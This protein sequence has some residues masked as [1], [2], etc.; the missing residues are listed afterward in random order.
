MSK[1]D[2]TQ[3][4]DDD[5]DDDG[6]HG[7]F[8]HNR[9]IRGTLL[10]WSDSQHWTDRDGLKAPTPLLVVGVNDALQRWIDNKPQVIF[11]KPLPNEDDLNAAIPISEWELG[12][13]GQRRKPWAHVVVVY[14]IDPAAGGFYTYVSATTGAHIA[15]D[16][17]KEAVMSMRML[18]GGKVLPLVALGERPMKTKFGVKTRPH[19]EV[20]DWKTSAALPAA[21]QQE[22]LQAALPAAEPG[23]KL[24]LKPV[25]SSVKAAAPAAEPAKRSWKLAGETLSAMGGVKPVTAA[26]SLDDHI[27]Y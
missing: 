9:L 4:D 17:L 15:F 16:A 13:D 1:N 5:D 26:E 6:F 10:R 18:R 12:V 3:Y 11:D 20:V 8:A 19:F 23:P 24:E 25:E 27:P 21:P 22:P 14:A 7:S 2:L